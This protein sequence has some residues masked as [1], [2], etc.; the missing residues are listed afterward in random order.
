MGRDPASLGVNLGTRMAAILTRT[1][2]DSTV[3]LLPHVRRQVEETVRVVAGALAAGDRGVVNATLE[4]VYGRSPLNETTGLVVERLYNIHPILATPLLAV[5]LLLSLTRLLQ[6]SLE[7]EV[8]NESQAAWRHSPFRALDPSTA[9]QAWVAGIIDGEQAREEAASGGLDTDRAEVLHALAQSWPTLGEA[10]ELFN[11]GVITETGARFI[12]ER[13]GY[14]ENTAAQLLQLR[15]AIPGPQDVVRFAVR[16]VYLPEAVA[17]GGLLQDLPERGVEDAARAGLTRA[18]FEKFW[19]AHWV[20]PSVTNA[21][22]MFHR[23]VITLDELKGL[24]RIQDIAPGW[25]EE[26]VAIAYNPLTRVDVRRMYR[27]GIL[28]K[29]QVHRAYLD[30]GYRPDHAELLTEFS[31]AD[32]TADARELTKAEV[33]ALYESGAVTR[34]QAEAMM[35]DL[36]YPEEEA[37]WLIALAEFKRLSRFRNLAISRVRSRYVGRRISDSEAATALDRLQMPTQERDALIDLW[38]AERD[39]ERPTL[40]P[41]LVG[42]LYRAGH[43]TEEE[44]RVRW[45]HAGYRSADIDLLV[46]NYADGNPEARVSGGPSRQLTK[47]DVGRALREG[48]IDTGQAIRAW[49]AMGYGEGD[50]EL[51]ARNYLP[52]EET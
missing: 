4:E 44:A 48:S 7:P 49:M 34:A 16:D 42:G 19:A 41:A 5:A 2:V 18:E 21:F 32:A 8:F 26:L 35:A 47:A 38:D 20:L 31:I 12:L 30:L 43:I 51:L 23:G 10:M 14:D 52:E 46:L 33:V 36:G 50:A 11:R 22:E 6:A 39:A 29:A 9:A 25:R 40:T 28:D 27:E 3:A 13:R 37:A 17:R 24:L 1:R 15:F 45:G